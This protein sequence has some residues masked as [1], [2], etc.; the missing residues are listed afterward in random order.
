MQ[1]VTDLF[2]SAQG[3]LFDSFVQPLLFGL[4]LGGFVEM[5]FEVIEIK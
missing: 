4:G 5:G 2:V 1:F 3:W